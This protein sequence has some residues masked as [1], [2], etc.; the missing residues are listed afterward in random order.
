[1]SEKPYKI[2]ERNILF[3]LIKAIFKVVYIWGFY[4]LEQDYSPYAA[5]G[6][7]GVSWGLLF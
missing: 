5:A 3:T 4:V 2:K 6:Y 1:M 7:L